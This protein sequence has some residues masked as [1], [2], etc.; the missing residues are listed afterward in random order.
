MAI[1]RQREGEQKTCFKPSNRVVSCSFPSNKSINYDL[2]GLQGQ[3]QLLLGCILSPCHGWYATWRT[4]FHHVSSF[5]FLLV[6]GPFRMF[7][8]FQHEPSLG[9]QTKAKAS[10]I[11]YSNNLGI[12]PLARESRDRPCSPF[13]RCVSPGGAGGQ[14]RRCQ[15]ERKISKDTQRESWGLHMKWAGP[16]RS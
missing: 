3:I 1:E 12:S 4:Q 5:M 15:D 10:W 16:T 13:G 8:P 14:S 11:C 6:V 2:Q 7:S 9:F